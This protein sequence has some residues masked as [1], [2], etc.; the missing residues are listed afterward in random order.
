MISYDSPCLPCPRCSGHCQELVQPI[1]S[2]SS[3]AER[4]PC[5]RELLSQPV[6]PADGADDVYPHVHTGYIFGEQI[7]LV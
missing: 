6:N 5:V 4:I 7:R 2:I 3:T 1:L